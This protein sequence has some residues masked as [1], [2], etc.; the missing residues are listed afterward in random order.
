MPAATAR[1]RWSAMGRPRSSMPTAAEARA[2][3][4]L[5]LGTQVDEAGLLGE[6]EG[7]AGENQRGG[8]GQGLDNGALAAEGAGQDGPK[9]SMGL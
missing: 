1:G 7:Q 8:L 2:H 5:A 3:V 9:A 4:E 6:G